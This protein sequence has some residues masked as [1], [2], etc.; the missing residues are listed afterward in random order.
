MTSVSQQPSRPSQP[1]SASQSYANTA[2]KA[3]SSPPIAT[4]SATP[5]PVV[6]V[7]GSSPAPLENGSDNATMNGRSAL[8]APA[9]AHS[10][11]VNGAAADHARKSSVTIS[12]NGPQSY[13]NGSSKAGIQFGSLTDSPAASHSRPQVSQAATA[14]PIPMANSSV[15]VPSPA[16]SPSPIPQPS[17]TGGARPPSSL[18]H[19]GGTMTFGSLG[20]EGD[21]R[22]P[23][24]R[25]R[26][27][28]TNLS[29]QRHMR[30]T[31]AHPSPALSV[32]Q[33]VGHTRRES[34]HSMQS[35]QNDMNTGAGRG[36]YGRGRG[37][38]NYNQHNNNYPQRPQQHNN[39]PP[40]QPYQTGQ[41]RGMPSAPFPQASTRQFQQPP[42]H[43]GRS[44]ALG[45]ATPGPGTPNMHQALPMQPAYPG[46]NFPN[47]PMGPH[48]VQHSS[49]FPRAPQGSRGHRAGRSGGRR[50]LD[51]SSSN[52]RSPD[53]PKEQ[54]G[55][56]C[57][58]PVLHGARKSHERESLAVGLDGT[59]MHLYSA[60]AGMDASLSLFS[61]TQ[62]LGHA[63]PPPLDPSSPLDF[64]PENGNFEHFL[65]ARQTFQGYAAY[66][67][68]PYDP[69]MMM[70]Y[71]PGPMAYGQQQMMGHG[72]PGAPGGP[73]NPN[74]YN[75]GQYTTPA[76]SM[77]RSTSQM[78][79]TRP[80]SGVQQP[81]TPSL[82]S[83]TPVQNPATPYARKP[84]ASAAIKIVRPDGETLDVDKIRE[85]KPPP[86]AKTPP[87][88]ASTPT[89]P[90]VKAPLPQPVIAHER[91]DSVAKTSEQI[92]NEIAE[93]V[94]AVA[95]AASSPAKEDA[96]ASVVETEQ[97]QTPAIVT[98]K[99]PEAEDAAAKDASDAKA[100]ADKAKQDEEDELER[101]IREME[102]AEA[103]RERKEALILEK[104][105][106]DKQAADK[107]KEEQ[108][109]LDGEENDRKLKEAERE[110]E[111]LEDE[112][113]KKRNE[114][115]AKANASTDVDAAKDD[116]SKSVS[117]TPDTLASKVATEQKTESGASTPVSD[118][119]M[120]PP[121]P[122]SASA[123]AEKRGKPA[124]LNLAPLNTKPVEPPQPSAALQS[125]KSA[126]FLT[127]L[128]ASL[129]PPNISS[130][131]P[132]LNAAVTTK[133]KSFKY[134][135]EFL[136]Q[137]KTVFTEKP[138][139]EFESQIKALLGDGDISA[140]AGG[141]SARGASSGMGARGSNRN[142]PGSFAMGSFGAAPGGRTLPPGTTSDQRVA[143]SSGTMARPNVNPMAAFAR[144]GAAF[145][146]GNPMSRTPSTSG[147][148]NIPHSPRQHS[149]STRGGSKRE[150]FGNAKSEAAAAKTMPLTAGMDIK[151]IQTSATGWKP[152]SL[153]QTATGAA[154][155][156][157][158]GA[159]STHME[160][161][162]VQRKVKAALNKMTPEKFEKIADQ[163]LS[164]AA[165]SK[166][167]ADGRTLRQVI[168]LT[169]E[170]A[171]DEAHWASMYAKFCKRMLETM[172]PE[173]KD[174]SI[175]DK[176]GNVVAGGNLFRKYLLNRCQE[177]FERGW[178]LAL[179]DKPEGER[180]EEKTEEAVMLSDEYY[181]A[182]AAKR[183]GLGLV[184]FIGE[185][186]K[187]GMLTE[188]IMHECVKKLVDYTGI[189]DEA[190][191]ESLTKL[192][193]TIGGNLDSTERGNNMMDV[194]F[195][196]IDG[197]VQ[198]P[199][200]PS[201]LKFMLMDI[202]DLRRKRWQSKE[203]NK[204]PKTLDEVR[205]EVRVAL[206]M[207]LFHANVIPG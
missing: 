146:G 13:V 116:D 84:R 40:Q 170:K 151:A 191:I 162:M 153:A 147:M 94:Q 54:T 186:Y 136:L 155:P 114:A 179:P 173:I 86:P 71:Q 188:R 206:T 137:F 83:Q 176:N 199:E 32:N 109:R 131:N 78:S 138:S 37:N 156:G 163:I 15:N 68:Q 178:K 57:E 16:Q 74:A 187:L 120:G 177:E 150:T 132:A 197:M 180:G 33:H 79:E 125:L 58:A 93:K 3:V 168:Q 164:I 5:S 59:L 75:P 158:G 28:F 17:T 23:S 92:K 160:P 1:A 195:Q 99:E 81:T 42:Q 152:R 35:V 80:G 172:S 20:N 108:R 52:W 73:Y 154:G 31:S 98:S 88:I 101:Q 126:R 96:S 95:K 70:N 10:S 128:N 145:P 64:S 34:S 135:K 67:Q 201:R 102:E 106:A 12:A 85:T 161:D 77:S 204:G 140:R 144:P 175:L 44:P 21:V 90:P 200:L 60:A 127:H 166:D 18:G 129:Y 183:R 36:N 198:T 139:V 104:R 107:L 184:Q 87:V 30:Q 26:R 66:A 141:G 194:Y 41:G 207:S 148:N 47:Q 61:P 167:E 39:F 14:V 111:R 112:R 157:P 25:V 189:P 149:R 103:E 22:S 182:A 62:Q 11:S 123:T 50:V 48:N 169:F 8:S 46:Y 2:K 51:K 69:R 130:P 45:H 110:M 122:R 185:L 43:G 174:E 121:P 19:Q 9:I 143:M 165:Q 72:M 196:R 63:L 105:K 53:P 142:A 4:G 193:K 56:P 29:W 100:A 82:P 115:E 65:T 7:G 113:E 76:A 203:A 118:D 119:S 55:H 27:A 117:A 124:A 192:L 190:E 202:I 6:A 24:T 97:P 133:G 159:S 181:I 49:T 91:K 134:D 89:P 171:T 38:N 205:V